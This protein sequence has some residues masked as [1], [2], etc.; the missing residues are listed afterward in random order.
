MAAG[1]RTGPELV[2]LD[3]PIPT[4]GL[5]AL[6]WLVEL[7]EALPRTLRGLCKEAMALDLPLSQLALRFPTC[8]VVLVCQLRFTQLVEKTLDMKSDT[9]SRHAHL[10]RIVEPAIKALIEDLLTVIN[11]PNLRSKW[12]D[13]VLEMLMVRSHPLAN[14]PLTPL[15]RNVECQK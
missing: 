14:G 5:P 6:Q 2:T 9:E 15:F 3:R 1:V 7:T 13:S 11:D 10:T 8:T 4:E 12:K